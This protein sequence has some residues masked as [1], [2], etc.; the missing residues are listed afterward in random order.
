MGESGSGFLV[1]GVPFEQIHF[2]ISDLSNPLWTRIHRITDQTM[3]LKQKYWLR[4]G[5]LGTLN[6]CDQWPLDLTLQ[7]RFYF[8]FI[9]EF[10][11]RFPTIFPVNTWN[12]YLLEIEHRWAKLLISDPSSK[13]TR[14]I[15]D[16]FIRLKPTQ[17]SDLIDPCPEWIR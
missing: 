10:V 1:C 2:Q 17:T 6:A 15:R 14:W 5:Y 13:G 7:N 12:T 8:V 4:Y 3:E 16:P 11:E 9:A